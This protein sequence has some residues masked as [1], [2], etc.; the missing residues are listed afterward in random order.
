M[1][2]R[3]IHAKQRERRLVALAQDLKTLLQ[4]MCHDVFE[5]A[6][7]SLDIRQELYDFI[8]TELQKLECKKHPAIRTLRKAL[9]KQ[10]DNL[11]AFAGVIDRKLVAIARSF[12]LPLQIVQEICLLFRKRPTSNPYWER[13]NQL[14]SQLSG[15]FHGVMKAVAKAL[16]QTPR[17]SS[18]VE[19]LNSRLR[20]YF[21]LRKS[22]NDSYLSLLQF[23]LNHRRFMRSQVPERVGKSPRELMTGDA[24]PH[25]L[26]MLGFQRFKR[27]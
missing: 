22:L 21:F 15:Q 7:P 24:H 23:F 3:L 11:L 9:R 4:W 8:V 14:H 19:N 6:G 25:W 27:A 2:S 12:S 13:W 17:A 26:E 16:K 10:R 5:L 1:T 20:N 18:L